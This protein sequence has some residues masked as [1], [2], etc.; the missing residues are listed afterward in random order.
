MRATTN[1]F[2]SPAGG[3]LAAFSLAGLLSLTKLAADAYMA[4]SLDVLKSMYSR[5]VANRCSDC[6]VPRWFTGAPYK[7][8]TQQRQDWG[9]S[10]SDGSGLTAALVAG[11][12][13]SVLNFWLP[14]TYANIAYA[15]LVIHYLV[16]LCVLPAPSASGPF[17]RN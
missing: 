7:A 6:T 9:G 4:I 2:V 1:A 12:R 13:Y 11:Y 16:S 14:F 17:S 3:Q 8:T 5:Q 15:A 10:S